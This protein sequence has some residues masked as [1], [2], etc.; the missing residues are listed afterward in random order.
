MNKVVAILGIIVLMTLSGLFFC[1]G[2]F[3]GTTIFPSKLSLVSG[4]KKDADKSMTLKEIED[5]ADIKSN[6]ISEKV[7][8]ILATA[9][10]NATE[11]VS[12]AAIK[13]KSGINIFGDDSRLTVDSLLREIAA[14]HTAEDDCSYE[15]TKIQSSIPRPHDEHLNG[16]KIVFIGYFKNNIA[17]N[18]QKLLIGKGYKAHV[19]RSKNG[20][21]SESF[22]F[23]G[24]FKKDENANALV[25]WLLKHD[26]SDARTISVS[27]E[28]IEETLY[29]FEND[30]SSLPD[31]VEKEIPV[32]Q[33]DAA[34]T[35][36]EA[37]PADIQAATDASAAI[38]A[39]AAPTLATPPVTTAP[40]APP[41]TTT[42]TTPVTAASA[43]QP[44]A[45]APATSAAVPIALPTL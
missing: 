38:P 15:K 45:T 41:V 26:F 27:N 17:M 24:P 39:S 21:G 40:A 25:L 18:I 36:T 13:Y 29:D 31:N 22:I 11:T 10:E 34:L 6:S 3:T 20:D 42:P 32:V 16:K 4:D 35:T 5:L 43:A 8:S 28:A 14:T 7:I 37:T 12:N 9:A 44:V 19:E 2:F 23:C 1:V 30:D 33:D